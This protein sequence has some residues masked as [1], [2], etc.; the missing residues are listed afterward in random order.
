MSLFLALVVGLFA[1][2]SAYEV[3]EVLN[4]ERY[5]LPLSLGRVKPR[6][7]KFIKK[8]NRTITISRSN[9][10]L[11]LRKLCQ[12][13]RLSAVQYINHF[14]FTNVIVF[15]VRVFNA[16]SRAYSIVNNMQP[17]PRCRETSEFISK[18]RLENKFYHKKRNCLRSIALIKT[19]IQ[20]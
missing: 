17:T 15:T 20:L 9:N 14:I 18:W 13:F 16:R 5:A 2:S 7:L 3:C 8:Q 6:L 12:K 19:H 4:S 1:A 10:T 11:Q